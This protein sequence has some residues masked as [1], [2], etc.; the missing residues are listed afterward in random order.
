MSLKKLFQK[1]LEIRKKQTAESLD[2]LGLDGL[3]IA[4]GPKKNYFLDDLSINFHPN[5]HFSHWC[6]LRCEENFIAFNKVDRPKL[7]LR[8]HKDFWHDSEVN[9]D[10]F[11]QESFEII[12]YEKP[13]ELIK[14]FKDFEKYTFLGERNE[15]ENYSF[16]NSNP[17]E[18]LHELNWQ[19][20]QK[21][22]YEIAC[23]KKANEKASVAHLAVK[24]AFFAGASELDLHYIYLQKLKV[25]EKDLPYASIIAQNEKAAILHY[26]NKRTLKNLKTFLIDAGAFELSYA[27]DISRTYAKEK[28]CPEVFYFLLKEMEKIQLELCDQVFTGVSFLNLTSKLTLNLQNFFL[29]LKF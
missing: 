28:T 21:S 11:W 24:D 1:H 10:D 17:K 9:Q 23:I 22:E 26:Q 16:K 18:L 19:R 5:P 27:S 7:F 25:Q 4:S 6:P 14:H 8:E 2:K 13:E 15:G 12:P 20:A 3:L 29:K